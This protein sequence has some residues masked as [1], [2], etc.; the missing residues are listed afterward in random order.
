MAYAAF[1]VSRNYAGMTYEH[2]TLA[3][4][5][6]TVAELRELYRAA[7]ARA[8]RLRLL[9]QAAGELIKADAGT[10]EEIVQRCLDQLAFF[11]GSRRA[12]LLA[13]TESE[14]IAVRAPGSDGGISYR[15][16]IE[17]LGSIEAV[18]DDEDR[19]ACRIL[20]D[21]VATAIE[22][23]EHERERDVLLAV[24]KD[25]E[26]R[27]ESLVSQIIGAQEEE[28]RRVAYELHDGVA[29][30]AT[31]LLRLLEGASV[32]SAQ[33][34]GVRQ[35]EQLTAVAR[36]LVKELRGVIAGLR[37]TIL[38][39]LGLSA[40]LD[41]LCD[42]LE[43]DG[44][45]V[46]R[47]ISAGRQRLPAAVETAL[48]RVA[49]EAISNIRKHAGAPCPVLIEAELL[50]GDGGP[51]LRITDHGHGPRESGRSRQEQKSGYNVGIDG[52]RERMATIGG[53][54]EWRAL[55]AGGVVVEARLTAAD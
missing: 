13:A 48:Y 3:G 31:A 37:P 2:P 42:D 43:R 44:Y 23:V 19:Q 14:G 29:Q 21:L 24:L 35:E 34:P 8:A 16:E 11:V 40:A 28:R 20:L 55:A 53:M 25:R 26:A 54:L 30:T 27:L 45:P 5:I 1:A 10:I 18:D 52:M 41:A 22:R 12:R 32:R 7:E 15:V 9:S 51:F 33:V 47:A 49:Q 4:E 50:Q 17:G 39:D 38:D 46:T 6:E 36:G